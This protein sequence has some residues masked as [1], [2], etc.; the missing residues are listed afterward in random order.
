MS[1]GWAHPTPAL[2][3]RLWERTT[4]SSRQGRYQPV[5]PRARMTCPDGSGEGQQ[6]PEAAR[7]T[8]HHTGDLAIANAEL[9][10]VDMDEEDKDIL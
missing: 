9:A 10:V 2:L 4:R 8:P 7:E 1:R 3:D 5:R 6:Q